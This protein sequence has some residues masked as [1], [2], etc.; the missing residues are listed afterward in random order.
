LKEICKVCQLRNSIAPPASFE[1]K[2]EKMI[3]KQFKAAHA[4]V[5]VGKHHKAKNADRLYTVI[6]S[7]K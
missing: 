6:I 1:F 5:Q 4:L 3:A 7:R 2:L